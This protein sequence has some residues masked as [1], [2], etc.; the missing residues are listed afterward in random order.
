MS[1]TYVGATEVTLV[2]PA[3]VTITG[4]S[5]PLTLGEVAS[6]IQ[7]FG[8]R[9]NVAAA[10]AGYAVPISPS[11]LD[12]YSMVQDAVI[13]GV[14]GWIMGIYGPNVPAGP[15]SQT[16]LAGQFTQA[17]RDFLEQLRDGD[18]L[19]PDV[20]RDTD[21]RQLPRSF[22]TTNT[23]AA[24]SVGGASPLISVKQVF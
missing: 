6:A 3:P 14:A 8:A 23:A 2:L 9:V 10:G 7:R 12:A 17:Y 21:G 16:T 11:A 13:Q 20:G 22:E 4:T 18:I 15:G 1:G 24:A 19:L 5:S